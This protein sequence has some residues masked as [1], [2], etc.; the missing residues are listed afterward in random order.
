MWKLLVIAMTCV[1]W[2]VSLLLILFGSVVWTV[3]RCSAVM[4]SDNLRLLIFESMGGC[5]V[6]VAVITAN[7]L[8]LF[9]CKLS[10]LTG[11]AYLS[12]LLPAVMSVS[13]GFAASDR[14]GAWLLKSRGYATE[15]AYIDTMQR[16]LEWLTVVFI[17]MAFG[18]E[19]VRR[20]RSQMRV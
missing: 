1:F 15:A 12:G 8:G 5:Y 9:R 19:I 3:E 20:R 7:Q 10:S 13:T 18:F 4:A 16:F 14:I 6:F 11:K 17:C 2:I